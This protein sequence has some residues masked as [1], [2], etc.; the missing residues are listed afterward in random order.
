[1]IKFVKVDDDQYFWRLKSPI[2]VFQDKE[3]FCRRYFE[4]MDKAGVD[5][6]ICPAQV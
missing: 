2:L 5:V 6:I 1:M 4:M 3:V